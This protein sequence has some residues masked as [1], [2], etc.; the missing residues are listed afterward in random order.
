MCHATL[1]RMSS[2]CRLLGETKV[3]HITT[4]TRECHG[5]TLELHGWYFIWSL[6]FELNT[7]SSTS[8][9]V[10][11]LS[12]KLVAVVFVVVLAGGSIV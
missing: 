7:C 12:L 6:L 9:V 3:L 4:T 1:Y 8:E 2:H 5:H 10:L 11:S